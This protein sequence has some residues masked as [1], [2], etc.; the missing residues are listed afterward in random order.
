MYEYD[1]PI[2]SP[3]LPK[4]PPP[5]SQPIFDD[6]TSKLA[7]KLSLLKSPSESQKSGETRPSAE[8]S[9][10]F[11]QLSLSIAPP[12]EKPLSARLAL[13]LDSSAVYA[14]DLQLRDALRLLQASGHIKSEGAY[15]LL[16]MPGVLGAAARRR[17]WIALQRDT[18][19][20][21]RNALEAA[22]QAQKNTQSIIEAVES[23][24][25]TNGA[26]KSV[27]KPAN[28]P[29]LDLEALSQLRAQKN[30]L[31]AKKNI[32]KALQ[33]T[34]FLSE[35]ERYLLL[36][37][38]E[39]ADHTEEYFAAYYKAQ[40][41]HTDCAVLLAASPESGSRVMAA[42]RSLAESAVRNMLFHVSHNSD[43]SSV[44]A[45]VRGIASSSASQLVTLSEALA[46]RNLSQLVSSL[47]ET[48][49]RAARH[50]FEQQLDAGSDAFLMARDPVRYV[51]DVLAAVHGAIALEKEALDTIF[52]GDPLLLG[53]DLLELENHILDGVVSAICA[54]LRTRIEHVVRSQSVVQV[55]SALYEALALHVMMFERQLPSGNPILAA[56]AG[57][58]ALLRERTFAGV[59][60]LQNR[61]IRAEG[62]YESDLQPPEWLMAYF[63]GTHE[64]LKGLGVGQFMGFQGEELQTLWSAILDKPLEFIEDE[65]NK[66]LKPESIAAGVLR[67]N[68]YDYILGKIGMVG[69]P[70]A[71]DL[72][73]K[74]ILE[75]L[76]KEVEHLKLEAYAFLVDQCGLTEVET[77]MKAVS[78]QENGET[79]WKQDVSAYSIL[80][81][82]NYM[83][84]EAVKEAN[85]RIQQFIPEATSHQFS[86]S[87]EQISSPGISKTVV[88]GSIVQFVRFYSVYHAVVVVYLNNEDEMLGTRLLEWGDLEIATL[89]GVEEAYAKSLS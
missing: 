69:K 48:R 76:A 36:L 24:M 12:P 74:A 88:E 83:G 8:M 6:L 42:A 13:V 38:K 22:K 89:L 4:S 31:V 45:C 84:V 43:I 49:S 81:E 68:C 80:L 11:A 40:R 1:P 58:Q 59:H 60:A 15:R 62:I 87:L 61:V 37:L 39:I 33:K 66:S 32:L 28:S 10:K 17:L 34:Y 53:P 18:L 14:D 86:L 35:Y 54:P 63:E 2:A 72:Q 78:K 77:G 71:V 25:A 50:E 19:Q 27:L 47:V 51:G 26:M 52:E 30:A 79:I 57:L 7:S 55:L 23:L 65:I 21:R 16:C 46:D 56:L 5:P 41:I 82:H 44:R 20:E 75:N 67:V 29:L 70:G 3:S 73:E 85:L 64:I 9:E